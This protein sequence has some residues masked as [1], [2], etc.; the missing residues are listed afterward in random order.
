[1]RGS[2]DCGD[3]L[4]DLRRDVLAAVECAKQDMRDHY[5]ENHDIMIYGV[6]L[7]ED[8]E[9]WITDALTELARARPSPA[10]RDAIQRLVGNADLGAAEGEET[11]VYGLVLG[12]TVV[13]TPPMLLD[14][15]PDCAGDRCEVSVRPQA[16]RPSDP[17]LQVPGW[18][19]H[20]LW[21]QECELC[22]PRAVAVDPAY[23]RAART[24]DFVGFDRRHAREEA[25]GDGWLGLDPE[26]CPLA[27]R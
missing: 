18:D 6:A 12:K 21:T 10:T 14:V 22:L 7:D 5:F 20:R 11:G 8:V 26:E 15:I 17:I 13:T 1:M 4:G 9:G 19:A 24:G 23:W 27:I 25:C 2:W 3:V 16:L